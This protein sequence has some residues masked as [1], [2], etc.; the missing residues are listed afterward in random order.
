MRA[1]SA[2]CVDTVAGRDTVCVARNVADHAAVAVRKY[3]RSVYL[4]SVITVSNR[5]GEQPAI[6]LK[7]NAVGAVLIGCHAAD[8]DVA[9]WPDAGTEHPLAT[10]I[11]GYE[12]LCS[13][14]RIAVAGIPA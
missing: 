14:P 10:D 13:Y 9:D 3:P 5:I 11:A 8:L 12:S 4:E 1:N 7:H 6:G 2:P